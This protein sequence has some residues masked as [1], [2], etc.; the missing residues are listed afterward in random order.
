MPALEPRANSSN[1]G[2]SGLSTV[3]ILIILSFAQGLVTI[4]ASLII[5]FLASTQQTRA[6]RTHMNDISYNASKKALGTIISMMDLSQEKFDER[7]AEFE[8]TVK[9]IHALGNGVHA[10]RRQSW[11]RQWR[12]SERNA[13]ELARIRKE[14]DDILLTLRLVRIVFLILTEKNH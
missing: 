10:I 4:F 14:F 6:N 2:P 3:D 7:K 9:K 5:V 11:F 13:E 12:N 1:A 8:N